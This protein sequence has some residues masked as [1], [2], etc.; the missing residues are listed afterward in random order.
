VLR[1]GY[2]LFAQKR[3]LPEWQRMVASLH[4]NHIIVVGVG[5]VGY[6]T[7][8]GLVALRESVVAIEQRADSEFLDEV[9]SL[10]VPVIS[11]NGRHRKILEQAGASRARAIIL[12]TDDDLANMDAALTAREINPAIRVVLRLF[13]DTLATKFASRFDM[14]TISTSEV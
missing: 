8:K 10:G 13:D 2:L 11:G 3:R 5:K 12:V 4:R 14:P 6:R 1:V 7:I 9:D